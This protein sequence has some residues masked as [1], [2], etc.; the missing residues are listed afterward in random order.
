MAKVRTAAKWVLAGCLLC[1]APALNAQRYGGCGYGSSKYNQNTCKKTAAPVK[2]AD[3]ALVSIKNKAPAGV[4]IY[5]N[6]AGRFFMLRIPA[7][8][9]GQAVA[10]QLYNEQGALVLNKSIAT[11]TLLHKIELPVLANGLYQVKLGSA[12]TTQTILLN[13]QN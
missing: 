8:Y 11:T 4:K 13:I 10:V 2:K 1:L 12:Q 5:P 7:S 3:T 6:P 9:K